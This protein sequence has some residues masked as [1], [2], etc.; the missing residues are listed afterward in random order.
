MSK[1]RGHHLNNPWF[2]HQIITYGRHRRHDRLVFVE[3]IHPLDV[4]QFCAN[5]ERHIE[6]LVI[7]MLNMLE[8]RKHGQVAGYGS[9]VDDDIDVISVWEALILAR[10]A[11][12]DGLAVG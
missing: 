11:A 12:L 6:D 2:N 9:G 5:E 4:A 7:S 10:L 8:Q 3:R 1:Q